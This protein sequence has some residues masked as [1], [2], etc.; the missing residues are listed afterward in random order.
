M[1]TDALASIKLY[2]S[3]KWIE[4]KSYTL[5][6]MNTNKPFFKDFP[7]PANA[8]RFTHIYNLFKNQRSEC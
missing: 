4:K 1:F 8:V 5:T 2:N 7:M 6:M 3:T